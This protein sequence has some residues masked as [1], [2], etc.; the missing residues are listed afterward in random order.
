MTRARPR[1]RPA[2]A[3][4]LLTTPRRPIRWPS[5]AAVSCSSSGSASAP[6]SRAARCSR[7]LG[8]REAWAAPPV[9]PNEGILLIVGMYGGNDG[10][11]TLV[12]FTDGNYYAQHGSLAI[13]GAADAAAQRSSRAQ[14]AAHL[15]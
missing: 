9:G 10:F 8:G 2:P 7:P 12:P 6:A 4:A 1:H 11:N 14:P 5:R 13:P 3:L 15:R